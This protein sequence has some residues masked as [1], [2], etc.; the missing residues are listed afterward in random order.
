MP[1]NSGQVDVEPRVQWTMLR[2]MVLCRQSVHVHHIYIYIVVCTTYYS[3]GSFW[4]LWLEYKSV[5]PVAGLC[6]SRPGFVRIFLLFVNPFEWT[7]RGVV[8][9][10]YSSLQVT[11]YCNMKMQ[12]RLAFS[13]SVIK[14]VS[15]E[16]KN[17]FRFRLRDSETATWNRFRS[18]DSKTTV[19]NY[20]SETDHSEH[21]N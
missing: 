7:S 8:F 10:K 4:A 18:H 1:M 19:G 13:D 3:I 2:S 21:F 5:C 11:S 17:N 12:L 14:Q 16:R 15:G 20:N 6:W 9:K